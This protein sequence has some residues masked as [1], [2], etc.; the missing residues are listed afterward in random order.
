MSK[1]LRA[2]VLNMKS[3][4][5]QISSPIL[6]GAGDMNGR[7][8]RIVFTQEAADMFTPHTKVYLKWYNQAADIRGYNVFQKKEKEEDFFS[9][10]VWELKFPRALLYEGDVSCTIELVDEYSISP[11]NGFIIR[12][13]TDPYDGSELET[14]DDFSAFQQAVVDMNSAAARAEGQLDQQKQDFEEIKN[15]FQEIETKS[16]EALGKIQETIDSVQP[17]LDG[18]LDVDKVGFDFTEDVPTIKAYIDNN[19]FAINE[20]VGEDV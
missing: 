2:Y 18:K 8:L 10:Q 7:T 13:T 20:F 6:I 15:S 1:E 16:N 12:V 11:S 19:L 17:M 5:Q 14:T 3:L 9:P 4:D